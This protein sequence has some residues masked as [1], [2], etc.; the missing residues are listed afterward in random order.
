MYKR[1]VEAFSAREDEELFKLSLYY[2]YDYYREELDPP[3]DIDLLKGR[4]KQ[5]VRLVRTGFLKSFESSIHS[6]EWRCNRM[7][8]KVLSWLKEHRIDSESEARYN[9]WLVRNKE[10]Y[11]HALNFTKKQNSSND[12]DEE[13]D[14]DE[15][16]PDVEKNKWS[17]E[18][19]HVSRIIDD[20]YTD[21]ELLAGFSGKLKK[22]NVEDDAK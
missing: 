2:P 1:Q 10:V 14:L 7:L 5:I 3:E 13:E 18:E 4:L 17:N 20:S 15:T 22:L 11:E 19:F 12:E 6:F 16:L 9:E 8:L 21:L